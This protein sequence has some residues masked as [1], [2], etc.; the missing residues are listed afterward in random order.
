MSNRQSAVRAVHLLVVTMFLW[1]VVMGCVGSHHSETVNVPPDSDQIK[2]VRGIDT[3]SSAENFDRTVKD[4]LP[5][6]KMRI[7]DAKCDEINPDDNIHF[8]VIYPNGGEVF[9]IGD[10]I[11]IRVCS[12][13]PNLH[14]L[15]EAAIE[16]TV[17]AGVRWLA[18]TGSVNAD[19]SV[20]SH[21]IPPAYNGFDENFNEI[22]VNPVSDNCLIRISSYTVLED[23]DHSDGSFKIIPPDVSVGVR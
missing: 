10:T 14:L 7:F 13:D 18:V 8:R 16:I 20:I 15:G 4:S 22:L 11:D 3:P 21:V 19:E 5:T 6:G 1:I 9:R 17:D 2:V 12:E 23:M